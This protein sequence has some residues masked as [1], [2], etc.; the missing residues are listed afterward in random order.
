MKRPAIAHQYVRHLGI[1][2]I[3]LLGDVYDVVFRSNTRNLELFRRHALDPQA[4][5]RSE[6]AV[7]LGL[8]LVVAGVLWLGFVALGALIDLLVNTRI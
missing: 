2:A 8:L 1:G 5:T 6:R 4:S 3:P 7:F